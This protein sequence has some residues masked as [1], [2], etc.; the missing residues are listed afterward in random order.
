MLE[1]NLNPIFKNTTPKKTYVK[2]QQRKTR[3]DK[4]H[5]ARFPVDPI[6][7]GDFKRSL[8]RFK[9]CYPEIKIEQTKYNTL[10]LLYGIHHMEIVNW[11]IHYKNYETYMTTKLLATKFQDISGDYGIAISKG[12][13]ERKAVFMLTVSA[14]RHIEKGGYYDEVFQQIQFDQV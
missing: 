1:N 6:L 4:R 12:L 3:S 9:R 7:Q 8:K 14:L 2:S 11:G 10:L 13:S 5:P